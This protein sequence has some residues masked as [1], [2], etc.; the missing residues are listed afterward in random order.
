MKMV[1]ARKRIS[2]AKI[3][4]IL[5]FPN[6]IAIQRDS[7][8]WFLEQGLANIFRDISPIEDFTGNLAI[9]FGEYKFDEIKHGVE[10][11]KEKDMTYSAPLFVDVNFINKETGEIKKQ[12]VFMGDFPLMTKKGTFVINGTER[13]VV[14]QLVRSPGVYYNSDIDKTTD[15]LLYHC[16][17]F[18]VG[19]TGLDLRRIKKTLFMFA[20]AESGSSR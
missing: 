20:S 15:R 4:E 17:L 8:K 14:S 5:D 13:V 9:E 1:N 10:E 11:C 16:R 19:G 6:L 18:P 2:F 12:Q 7:F 3:P